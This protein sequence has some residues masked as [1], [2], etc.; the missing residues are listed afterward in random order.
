M[1]RDR[2]P[3]QL[4]DFVVSHLELLTLTFHYS[5]FTFHFHFSW[6]LLSRLQ[7]DFVYDANDC[8]VHR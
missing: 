2:A 6:R 3:H 7:V 4:P 1:T 8:R 5:L